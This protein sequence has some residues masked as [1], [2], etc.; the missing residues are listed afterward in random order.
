MNAP[1]NIKV[2]ASISPTIHPSSIEPFAAALADS[3]ATKAAHAAGTRALTELYTGLS[4]MDAA[5]RATE[6][7]FGTGQVGPSG[8]LGQGW[9]VDGAAIRPVLPDDV[10]K[11]LAADMGDRFAKV[12]RAYDQNLATVN[13]T[14]TSLRGQIDRALSPKTRDSVAATNMAQIRDHIKALPED[15]RT[16]WVLDRIEKD[17][18]LE[19]AQAVTST[20]GW[21]SGLDRQNATFVRQAAERRFAPAESSRLDSLTKLLEHLQKSSAL[22]VQKYKS[23]VPMLRE[24]PHIAATAKLRGE[25]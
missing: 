16:Q 1:S 6:S 19:I 20:S 23:M 3:P 22:F 14:I 2:D 17:G 25:G 7:K 13:D 21:T 8:R 10:S 11:R 4:D 24:Q 12:A 15:R 9:Q 5:L 18:D